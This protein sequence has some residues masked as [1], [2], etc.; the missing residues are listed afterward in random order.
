MNQRYRT[1]DKQVVVFR[2]DEGEIDAYHN[3]FAI[4]SENHMLKRTFSWIHKTER[5]MSECCL[6]CKSCWKVDVVNVCRLLES[7]C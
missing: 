5:L 2:Q 3:R 7:C 1:K 6:C 4:E